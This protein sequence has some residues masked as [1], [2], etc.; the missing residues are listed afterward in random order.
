M[1]INWTAIIVG[2]GGTLLGFFL[3]TAYDFYIRKAERKD[4]Y[5]FALLNKRF[6]IYQEANLHCEKLKRVPH[7]KTEKKQEILNSAR[8]WFNM[9]CLY[10]KP[11]LRNKFER[12]LFD[13]DLYSFY[14]EDFYHTRR[15]QG[16]DHDETKFKRN[17]LFEKWGNIMGK[18]QNEI[19][20]D[21]DKYFEI[22]D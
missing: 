18:T 21:L 19:H 3:K 14:L 12:L 17:E 11:E 22:I 9:N 8:D 1:E 13:V 5:F 20:R 7:D 15:E 10:L 2:L 4:Q 6:E 16:K